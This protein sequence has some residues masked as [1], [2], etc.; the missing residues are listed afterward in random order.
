MTI[1]VVIATFNRA[2]V[3]TRCLR[4]L[5]VQSF[6]PGDEIVVADNGST[7]HTARVLREQALRFPVPL[8][9]VLEARPGKSNAVAAAVAVSTGHILAFTD[10]DVEVADDW[11]ARIRRAMA[12]GSVALVGGRVMPRFE[13]RVPPWLALRYADSFGRLASP[14]ALLDYGSDRQP[15]GPRTALGANLAITRAA[16]DRVGGFPTGLGKLRGT[17]LTGEDHLLCERVQQAGLGADYVPD[18]TV[19]HLVPRERLRLAYFLRWFFWSG[20]T[21]AAMSGTHVGSGPRRRFR[22]PLH[23]CRRFLSATLLTVASMLVGGWTQAATHAMDG[24]LAL[25]YIWASRRDSVS[26]SSL[27][28]DDRR[29]AEAA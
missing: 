11:L 26:V 24:A 2:G 25:G 8:R 4:S 13:G 3:L 19:R 20:V 17:L 14:L 12:D 29:Q 15:L 28:G 5:A 1:S 18:I 22:V 10:D 27:A 9:T 23:W 21:H 16:F 7:D 6:E